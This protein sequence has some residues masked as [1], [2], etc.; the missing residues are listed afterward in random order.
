MELPQLYTKKFLNI[1]S[2]ANVR[3][4]RKDTKHKE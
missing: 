1:V 3:L 4:P 2:F